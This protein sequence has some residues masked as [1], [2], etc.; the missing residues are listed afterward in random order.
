[1]PQFFQKRF[2]LN[3]KQSTLIRSFFGN[4][5]VFFGCTIG[6]L[7]LDF[8][9]LNGFFN[10]YLDSTPAMQYSAI[11]SVMVIFDLGSI[12]IG[13]FLSNR[14]RTQNLVKLCI[15]L[16]LIGFVLCIG[17]VGMMRLCN[18]EMFYTDTSETDLA[19]EAGILEKASEPDTAGQSALH[20][21][22]QILF[23]FTPFFTSV[24]SFFI[25]VLYTQNARLKHIEK[26]EQR[27]NLLREKLLTLS[28]SERVLQANS[29]DQNSAWERLQNELRDIQALDQIL[30]HEIKKL[31]IE[32]TDDP[33]DVQQ[34]E[35]MPVP[36]APPFH[37]PEPPKE[38]IPPAEKK[39]PLADRVPTVESNTLHKPQPA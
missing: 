28:N 32:N 35:M 11:I 18:V 30:K 36:V 4:I 17:V 9:T 6:L 39:T 23:C 20:F 27:L 7:A 2:T 29:N 26:L 1:M 21:W 14:V 38:T 10:I 25:S 31:Y 16:V 12:L 13:I 5:F 8:F 33:L 3:N 37:A 22:T 15:V 24:V 19:V 34:A